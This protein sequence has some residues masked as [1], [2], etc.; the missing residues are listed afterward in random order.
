MTIDPT[1]ATIDEC[2]D[3]LYRRKALSD[4][5]GTPHTM[6]WASAHWDTNHCRRI[7]DLGLHPFPPTLDAAA[8][9]MPS[10]WYMH[11]LC[12]NRTEFGTPKY[13]WIA[14]ASKQQGG[15]M[16]DEVRSTGETE[17]VTRFRLAVAC[18]MVED[19]AKGGK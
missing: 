13:P 17:I 9:A 1:T 11:E 2:R 8:E 15:R 12:D 5:I 6:E 18:C 14:R 3:W 19:A 4:L 16:P 7:D 10:G